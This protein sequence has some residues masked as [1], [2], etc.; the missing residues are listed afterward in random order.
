[1]NTYHLDCGRKKFWINL[2][3]V[4][5]V[6]QECPTEQYPNGI[7]SIKFVDGTDC[8]FTGAGN[9]QIVEDIYSLTR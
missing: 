9:D 5:E 6:I 7:T 8:T 2:D 3:H 4:V 1:M